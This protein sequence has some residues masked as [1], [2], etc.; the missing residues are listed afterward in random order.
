[1]SDT[2]HI[3]MEASWKAQL[4]NEFAKPYMQQ[5]KTF[6]QQEKQARK[7]IYPKSDHI[8]NAFNLTPFNE[9]K[10]VIIGQDPYHGPN[11][12][13]GLCFSVLPGVKIP[14]SLKNIYKE[15]QTDLNIKPVNHGFLES[16]AKQGVLLLNAV[17]T[18]EDGKAASHQGRGWEQF[19]D[20]VIELLNQREKPVIF[21][22][23][24]KYA[25]GKAKLINHEKHTVLKSAHPSPFSAHQGFLGN[26]H[27]S[28]INNILT[29]NGMEAINWQLPETV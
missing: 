7:L 10:V 27:F 3:K 21:V 22:L 18:V 2:D 8:F 9:V 28:K 14:P 5:L 11:Q 6:L 20:H 29:S 12:A 26:K 23:W 19:T 24:G 4:A 13:H 25:E 17:L 15:L 16:W 1:M